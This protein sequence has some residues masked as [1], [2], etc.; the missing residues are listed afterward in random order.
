MSETA[1]VQNTKAAPP[2]TKGTGEQP[3]KK[4][5]E[6]V[7]KPRQTFVEKFD[8]S[9]SQ[10]ERVELAKK[11]AEL[12]IDPDA[13]RAMSWKSIREHEDVCLKSDEFHKIIRL[14]DYYKEAV[15]NRLTTLIGTGFIYNGNLDTLCGIEVPTDIVEKMEANKAAAKAKAKPEKENSDADADA[16]K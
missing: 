6:K 8:E 11:V 13:D 15:L 12:R 1:K 3:P 4:R 5:Q 2:T 7:K 9:T 14:S 16:K 10:E